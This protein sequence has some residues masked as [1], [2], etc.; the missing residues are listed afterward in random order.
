M[1]N[2]VD[3]FL[4]HYASKYYDPAKARAY[5][6]KTRELKGREPAL[7][8]QS[9][10]N[11]RQATAY[12]SDQI[13]TRRTADLTKNATARTNLDKAA[14]TQAEAHAARMEKLQT[15]A[16]AAREQI[17]TKLKDHL[18]KLRDNLKVPPNASP[19]LRA[20]LEKQRAAQI[21]TAADK[22]QGEMKTLQDGLKASIEKA[23]S[24]YQA[25][26]TSNTNARRDN[27]TQ[28]RAISDGYRKDLATEK[29]NIK[30]QVR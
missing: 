25:F 16:T 24:E 7:S 29:Q 4:A 9:R 11:Q 15:E 8:K 3:S 10:E 27:A 21:G 19:K 5:Y 23:R 18:E 22:A 6:L 2:R 26:R 20:F 1:V 13:S 14:K 30:D 12:V 28:R 17:V